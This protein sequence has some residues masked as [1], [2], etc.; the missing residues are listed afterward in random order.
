MFAFV[1]NIMTL[2]ETTLINIKNNK[3]KKMK[4]TVITLILISFFACKKD[5]ATSSSG[6]IGTWHKAINSAV[7]AYVTLNADGTSTVG[8]DAGAGYT[9]TGTGTF[10][11]T[12]TQFTLLT[13]AGAN[14][15]PTTQGVYNWSVTGSSLTNTL[16]NDL[17][18]D[19]S[20]QARSAVISGTWSK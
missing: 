11:Y 7:T 13:S 18:V 20:G 10:S 4:L 3:M 2:Y 17:C 19:G 15:C 5:P 12:A 6:L 16:V 1:F 9:Q 14:S 8:Y